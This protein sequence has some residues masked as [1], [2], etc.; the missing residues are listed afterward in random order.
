MYY[1]HYVHIMYWLCTYVPAQFPMAMHALIAFLYSLMSLY[2]MSLWSFMPCPSPPIQYRIC[3]LLC[4][5]FHVY[6]FG[7]AMQIST[8]E[9]A[10]S[11]YYTMT[12]LCLDCLF[13]L[14]YSHCLCNTLQWAC[15]C[16]GYLEVICSDILRKKSCHSWESKHYSL[17]PQSITLPTE[18]TQPI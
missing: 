5:V 11:S 15:D 8:S 16:Y 9:K 7:Y 17:I 6:M 12:W 10:C 18:P 3:T 4:I 13:T 1:V 14:N 2:Y